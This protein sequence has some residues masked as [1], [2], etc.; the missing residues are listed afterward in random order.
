[1][2]IAAVVIITLNCQQQPTYPNIDK[3]RNIHMVEYPIAMRVN[4]LLQ[5]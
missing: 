1:M 3:W 5:Y 2:L 4:E